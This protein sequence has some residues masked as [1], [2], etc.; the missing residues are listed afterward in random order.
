MTF[1]LWNEATRL[2]LAAQLRLYS[3]GLLLYLEA[4]STTIAANHVP[5]RDNCLDI[6]IR[7][8]NQLLRAKQ[9]PVTAW[10]IRTSIGHPAADRSKVNAAAGLVPFTRCLA[11]PHMPLEFARQSHAR[12]KTSETLAHPRHTTLIARSFRCRYFPDIQHA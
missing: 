6:R 7:S 1:H 2:R 3:G 5:F 8:E 10:I 11:L 4:L 12:V 9:P